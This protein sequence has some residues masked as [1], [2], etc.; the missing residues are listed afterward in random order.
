MA[1][2]VPHGDDPH[3]SWFGHWPPGLPLDLHVP[4][5]TIHYNLE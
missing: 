4:E 1:H 2:I 5:T 3:A